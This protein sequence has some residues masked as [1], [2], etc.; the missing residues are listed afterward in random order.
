MNTHIHVFSLFVVDGK[1]MFVF[2]FYFPLRL[3]Y[4]LWV[5]TR[6]VVAV[7]WHLRVLLF[8]DRSAQDVM[9]AWAMTDHE[10]LVIYD[11]CNAVRL[12][13]GR[14]RSGPA[15][16]VDL[17]ACVRACLAGWSDRRG[18]SCDVSTDGVLSRVDGVD[19]VVGDWLPPN[20]RLR[21]TSQTARTGRL[22]D[23]RDGPLTATSSDSNWIHRK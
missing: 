12:S 5:G 6:T 9:V 21:H 16:R 13:V 23:C 11:H 18:W 15:M 1:W 22:P 7:M 14:R 20:T 2:H 8:S 4:K 19:A 17:P 10:L 3:N